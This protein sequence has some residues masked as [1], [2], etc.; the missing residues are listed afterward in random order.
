VTPA[1]IEQ[2][3]V[4]LVRHTSTDWT[5][6]RYC[7]AADPPLNEAGRREADALAAR[8]VPTLPRDVRLISS[9]LRRALETATAIARAAGGLDV[10]VDDHWREVDMGEAEGLTYD[11][12]QAHWPDLASV[13]ASGAADI[14][15][16]GGD[17]A[18]ALTS[19]LRGA[20]ADLATQARPTVVVSHAG[21]IRLAMR[22]APADPGDQVIVPP[23]G[24][25]RLTLTDPFRSGA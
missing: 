16:P 3:G 11:E 19:R 25:I 18:G 5:G 14:A 21:P 1:V 20:L 2:S 13:L 10:T 23:G 22:L 12:V 7:G 4:I 9:P 17:A 6:V 8:L 24:V 15:W